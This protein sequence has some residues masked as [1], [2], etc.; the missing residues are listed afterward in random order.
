M[1]WYKI[2]K[3]IS[4][5]ES[6]LNVNLNGMKREMKRI[7]ILGFHMVFLSNKRE[8]QFVIRKNIR[9]EVSFLKHMLKFYI[10]SMQVTDPDFVH[11]I[12]YLTQKFL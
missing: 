6:T 2:N 4:S 5:F 3:S 8:L 12:N 7:T 1:F 9:P 11:K 10:N